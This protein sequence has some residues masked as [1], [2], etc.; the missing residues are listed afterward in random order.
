MTQQ[1]AAIA[2][3]RVQAER[4][5]RRSRP[6]LGAGWANMGFVA[7]FLVAYAVLLLY[8]MVYGVWISFQ[9]YDLFDASARYVGWANYA[10][11]LDDDIFRGAVRNTFLF[12][13]LTVPTFLVLGLG[14]AL[15]LNRRTRG[16]AVLRAIFFGTSILSVTIV[17][18]V[19]KVV[20][21]PERGLLASLFALVGAEAPA[22]LSE[23]DL[24]L[25][26]VA[27][28]T[29][30]W[31]L[32]LPM[33]L[34]LAALQQIP[35]ELYEA[36]ALDN[37]SRWRTFRHITLPSIRRTMIV[38]V[39]YEIV[40]QFQL[41]GQSLL[42]TGGGPSNATRSIVQFVYEQGFRDWDMG[43]AAAASEVLFLIIAVVALTQYALLHRRGEG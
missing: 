21:I 28:T 2:T 1:E 20:F 13:A 35:D 6:K 7:P 18:I 11:L 3:S 9:E 31:V 23:P 25:L 16:A 12:V 30:W 40:A 33:I 42:L 39:I 37:A 41:F 36:A 26:A 4:R 22:F 8:P 17:T 14:L 27:I 10:R 5:A 34:F 38:V 29:V 15:A 32:G 24:A 19:W 43:Y